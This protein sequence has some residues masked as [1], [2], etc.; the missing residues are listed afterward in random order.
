MR[1][2]LYAA[3]PPKLVH[4]SVP[5]HLIKPCCV[6]GSLLAQVFI[7]AQKSVLGAIEGQI[8]ISQQGDQE[9]VDRPLVVAHE[10]DELVFQRAVGLHST[11]ALETI[12]YS[13]IRA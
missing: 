9:V 12:G 5:G 10:L 2:R 3:L 1:L 13:S 11:L 7:G 8:R 6:D 4:R